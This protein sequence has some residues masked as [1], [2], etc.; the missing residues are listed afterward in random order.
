MAFYGDLVP[1]R[2]EPSQYAGDFCDVNGKANY[3]DGRDG[4]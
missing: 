4:S 1:L 3:E 2:I